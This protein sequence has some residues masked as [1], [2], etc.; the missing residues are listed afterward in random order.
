[1]ALK[2]PVSRWHCK[3]SKVTK[4]SDPGELYNYTKPRRIPETNIFLRLHQLQVSTLPHC[5]RQS[6]SVSFHVRFLNT[7]KKFGFYLNVKYLKSQLN[8]LSTYFGTTSL[9][10]RLLCVLS[11]CAGTMGTSSNGARQ[12]F[13]RNLLQ[14][15]TRLRRVGGEAV[16]GRGCRGGGKESQGCRCRAELWAEN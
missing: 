11:F 7:P 5:L 16:R 13:S 4:E 3:W 14:R 6:L 1:M 9:L 8:Q 2:V 15:R 12:R 10:H